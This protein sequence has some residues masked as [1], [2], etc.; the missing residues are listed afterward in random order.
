MPK[1]YLIAVAQHTQECQEDLNDLS[2][3]AKQRPFNRIER[4]AAERALQVLIGA[5]IGM[6]KYCLKACRKNIPLDAYDS[7]NKLAEMGKLSTDELKQWR[8]IIDMRNALVHDYMTIDDKLLQTLLS[9]QAYRFLVEFI[10][11]TK[12]QLN[13]GFD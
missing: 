6:A 1:G 11:N 7:F 9:E 5:G 10:M 12:N 4:R 2:R 3:I 8:K 13:D